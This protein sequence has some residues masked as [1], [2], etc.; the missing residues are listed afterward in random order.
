[1]TGKY[2][3]KEEIKKA[4]D[5]TEEEYNTKNVSVS[6]DDF[7]NKIIEDCEENGGSLEDAIFIAND[8]FLDLDDE[9]GKTYDIVF[10]D[11][12]KSDCKG[13]KSSFEDCRSYIKSYNGTNDSYFADY[14]GGEVSIVCN[15]TGDTVYTEEVR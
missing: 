5:F 12:E 11:D 14:K 6:F 4:I 8:A 9:D 3:K 13:F 2:M 15:E 7:L 1:M 10:N